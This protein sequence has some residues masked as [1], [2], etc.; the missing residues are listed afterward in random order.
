MSMS[1]LANISVLG[2]AMGF[3][4]SAVVLPTLQSPDSD[5]KIDAHQASWIGTKFMN[6]L[7]RNWIYNFLYD[8]DVSETFIF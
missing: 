8:S 7:F 2:P 1:I 3:G 4:Y 5:I 6:P